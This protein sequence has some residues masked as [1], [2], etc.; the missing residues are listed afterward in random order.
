MKTF[1]NLLLRFQLWSIY[2]AY[3]AG[4]K[5][6]IR[7]ASH[8]SEDVLHAARRIGVIE[9]REQV[10]KENSITRVHE[11][12]TRVQ[13]ETPQKPLLLGTRQVAAQH[14]F[15]IGKIALLP[16]MIPTDKLPKP[17]QEQRAAMNWLNS[18]SSEL[19][20]VLTKEQRAKIARLDEQPPQPVD[21]EDTVESAI[22]TLLH[23]R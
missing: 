20:P 8:V 12:R 11:Y 7:V 4:K 22:V 9:G 18:D 16:E 14:G 19:L 2:R 15:P 13:L 6:G 21:D 23:E 1:R 10:Y 17:S 5:R 3:E